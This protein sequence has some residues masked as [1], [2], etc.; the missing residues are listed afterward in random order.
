[1]AWRNEAEDT[2]SGATLPGAG[3]TDLAVM[4]SRRCHAR[5]RIEFWDG[6]I[7]AIIYGVAKGKT[8]AAWQAPSLTRRRDMQAARSGHWSRAALRSM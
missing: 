4:K 3:K 7:P 2:A 5:S 1:M 6:S 8:S